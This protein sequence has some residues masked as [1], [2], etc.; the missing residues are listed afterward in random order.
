MLRR[1]LIFAAVWHLLHELPPMKPYPEGARHMT[2]MAAVFAVFA[3]Y[4]AEWLVERLP[5]RSR[6]FALIAMIAAIAIV[7]AFFSYHL[8]QS[9]PDDTQLV[10]RRIG[11]TLAEPVISGRSQ[12]RPSRRAS[13]RVRSE[14]EQWPGFI[15]LNELFAAISGGA[16]AS[17][18]AAHHARAHQEL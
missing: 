2:V 7:P 16:D 9:A 18:P 1:L 15:V 11:A 5:A 8:V 13:S 12:P 4:A 3:A 17:R 6:S 14:I 10:V